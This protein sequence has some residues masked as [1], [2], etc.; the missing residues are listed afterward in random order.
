M[1]L[2]M[3]QLFCELTIQFCLWDCQCRNCPKQLPLPYLLSKIQV[4]AFHRTMSHNVVL[5]NID[6]SLMGRKGSSWNFLQIPP[7]GGILPT[8][9]ET[10]VLAFKLYRSPRS[11]WILRSSPGAHAKTLCPYTALCVGDLQQS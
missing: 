8:R 7:W 2:S 5:Q 1:L 4:H 10:G 6:H 11:F 3:W 9:E